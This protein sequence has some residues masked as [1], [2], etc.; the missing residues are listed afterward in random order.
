MAPGEVYVSEARRAAF[1]ALLAAH[2]D[3]TQESRC[4]FFKTSIISISVLSF[5][6]FSFLNF[7]HSQIRPKSVA[8]ETLLESVNDARRASREL[9]F[10]EAE[11]RFVLETLDREGAVMFA[12]N[13]VYLT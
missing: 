1:Q 10:T 9:L 7:S 13:V 12:D 4:F 3:V 2:L 6:A 11:A 8:F 5:D